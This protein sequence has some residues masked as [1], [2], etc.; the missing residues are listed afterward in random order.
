[1][2][3][4]TTRQVLMGLAIG[5]V[6]GAVAAGIAVLDPP[7][8]VR[9]RE[10]DL[11]RARDL[12]AISRGVRIHWDRH[13]QLPDSLGALSQTPDT[14]RETLDPMTSRPYEY[15]VIEGDRYELCASFDRDSE[16]RVDDFWAHGAGRHCFE[17]EAGDDEV[18]YP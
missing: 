17:L 1:M 5:A 18:R 6:A 15:R 13:H 9:E 7:G 14:P 10:L 2:K 8:V 3:P 12:H 4:P 11:R 16:A